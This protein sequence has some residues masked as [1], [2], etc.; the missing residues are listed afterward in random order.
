MPVWRTEGDQDAAYLGH[1]VDTAG[2][3]NGDGFADVIVGAY[4]WGNGESSKGRAYVYLGSPSGLSTTP[5]W[6]GE[7]SQST[8]RFGY[9][10]GGAGDVN[11][12]GFDDV[13]VGSPLWHQ[14]QPTEG[15]ALVY[16][17]SALGVSTVPG[18]SAAGECRPDDT[19]TTAPT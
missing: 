1:S 4:L 14:G 5:D 7:G 11:G 16:F 8:A 17:G 13:I 12:D 3:V 15:R 2:D 10:V 6:T 18:W 19:N 9:S